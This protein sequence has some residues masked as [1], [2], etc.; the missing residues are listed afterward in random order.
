[1]EEDNQYIL[2]GA[3]AEEER[4]EIKNGIEEAREE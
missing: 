2:C 1:V 3:G 4:K